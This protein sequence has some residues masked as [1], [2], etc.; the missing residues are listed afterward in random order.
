MELLTNHTV[1]EEEA[2]PVLRS[3][4]R[5]ENKGGERVK[6]KHSHALY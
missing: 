1:A 4:T 6:K 3:Q 5:T 2:G